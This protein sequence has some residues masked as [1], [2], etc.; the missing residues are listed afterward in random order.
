MSF[1]TKSIIAL[2]IALPL[3]ISSISFAQTSAVTPDPQIDT[4]GCLIF[5]KN[6]SYGAKGA[7]VNKLQTFLKDQGY[8]SGSVT[9]TYGSSTRSAIRS[10][11]VTKLSEVTATD[12]SKTLVPNAATRKSIANSGF[13]LSNTGVA[14]AYTRAKIAY[15]SCRVPEDQLACPAPSVMDNSGVCSNDG[16]TLPVI[17]AQDTHQCADGN[18]VGRSG[19]NCQFVCE[20]A[21]I[22]P[23]T[24]SLQVSNLPRSKA[25]LKIGDTVTLMWSASQSRPATTTLALFLT[26]TTNQHDGGRIAVMQATR[27]VQNGSYSWTIPEYIFQSDIGMPL[28]SGNYKIRAILYE[29]E[30]ICF[31]Y[32][33]SGASTSPRVIADTTNDQV[34]TIEAKKESKNV[35]SNSKVIDL[36]KKTLASKVKV[37]SSLISLVDIKSRV[38]SNGCLGVTIP[39]TSCTMALVNGYAVKVS[40]ASV[41]YEYHTNHDGSIII[42]YIVQVSNDITKI[43]L[44]QGWYY[45]DANQKKAGTPSDWVLVNSGTEKAMWKA[46]APSTCPAPGVIV[47]GVCTNDGDAN[48][49]VF[50]TVSQA[51]TPSF[52]LGAYTSVV[53]TNVSRNLHRGAESA[54]VSSLQSFLISKGLLQS[55]VTGFY[56][57]KTVQAVK[58][59]QGSKGLPVTGMVYDFT[60]AAIKAESCQ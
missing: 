32:C 60:R 26:S 17:C 12:I 14:N 58:D 29:G 23:V 59:Y 54:S 55:E 13:K 30:N 47:K 31:G 40:Y 43:E 18:W 25:N 46:P 42:E 3:T 10:F 9:G 27:N 28:N 50:P 15:V 35:I 6:L 51:L 1:F 34:F 49:G 36:V 39:E 38:W 2:F 52:V 44:A 8:L 56:G 45:G 53:C 48:P 7:N 41:V 16:D 19:S 22:T 11:Q 57:D 20:A 37:D 21:P 24:A 4:A 5:S 33:V